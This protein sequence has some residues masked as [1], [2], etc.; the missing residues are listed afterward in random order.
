MKKVILLFFVMSLFF[1][2][3]TQEV[4]KGFSFGALPAIS[5]ES[6]LG[7]QYGALVNL[8]DYGD[9]KSFPAYNHSLYMELSTYTKGRVVAR[10]RYDT[11]KVIPKIRSTVDV[12]YITDPISDFYGFNGYQSVYNPDYSGTNKGFYGNS[13]TMFR[14]KTDFQGIFGH[15][16]F[17]WVGG[18]SFYQF[19]V[20]TL[21]LSRLGRKY[22]GEGLFQK[23]RRWGLIEDDEA[24]GGNLNY[25]KVGLKYDSRDQLACP[26]R[27]IFTE[28]VI[29]AAP[30][31]L[32]KNPHSKFSLIHRQYY[33]VAKDLVFAY[34]LDYQ[35]TIGAN[36]VPFYAQPLL[37]TSYLVAITNQGLGGKSSIR[38]ALRNRIVGDDIAFGNFELRYKLIRF[39]LL[40]Q[41]FYL[42]SNLFF[43]SGVI[44]QPI[45]IDF[46]KISNEE[47]KLYFDEYESGKLHSAL[48]LG[49][50]IG[51]NENFVIS[52]EYGRALNKQDGK[53]GVYIGLNYLF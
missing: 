36:K 6:D 27:G 22:E 47:R 30:K 15:S 16:H 4:K 33:S 24:S 17:G 28:A 5:Y 43:D 20:D 12:S 50:K 25:L 44:L 9:G 49:L 52:T 3:Y 21:N 1:G 38:G 29:Q 51:W 14:A 2:A 23:Y 35:A 34:R 41:S 7:F 48:G 39:N 53:S 11:E 37:T 40:K 45:K 42:G 19:D 13:Q 8:Y 32:N 26:T 10:V 46:S 31:Y 18:Y